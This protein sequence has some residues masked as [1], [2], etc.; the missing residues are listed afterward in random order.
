MGIVAEVGRLAACRWSPSGAYLAAGTYA[1]AVDTSFEASSSLELFALDV[2]NGR[3][4]PT[5]QPVPVSEK[6]SSIAWGPSAR[7]KPSG[8]IGGGLDDGTVAVWDPAALFRPA[9]DA[10]ARDPKRGLLFPPIAPPKHKGSVNSLEFNA[11]VGTLLA[12]GGADGQVLVWDL[13]SGTPSVHAPGALEKNSGRDEIVAIAWNKKVQHILGTGSSSGVLSVWD[14]RSRKQVISIRNPRGRLRASS[15]AWHPS[16]PTQI[17]VG[18]DEDDGSGAQLW[19]LRNATAPLVSLNHHAPRG[20]LGMS[21]CPH[22]T[23]LVLTSSRDCRTMV[24]SVSS[25]NL[26]ME[27]PKSHS[28]NFGVQWSPRSPGVYLASTFDGRVSVH[29]MLTAN[30][31][32]SVSEE[33]AKTLARLFESDEDQ[34]KSGMSAQSPRSTGAQ[35]QSVT[36]SQPPAWLRRPA[37]VSFSFGNIATV[38]Q[39]K[40]GGSVSLVSAAEP[41]SVLEESNTAVDEVLRNSSP[42]DPSSAADYCAKAASEAETQQDRMAWDVLSMQFKTDS[43][44]ELLKYF[45]YKV[46]P[47]QPGDMTDQVLGMECS[48]VLANPVRP[49]SGADASPDAQNTNTLPVSSDA[50]GT[51]LPGGANGATHGLK[52]LTL[53]GP[54]P[55]DAPV[56]DSHPGGDSILDDEQHND[57]SVVEQTSAAPAP[58]AQDSGYAKGTDLS[59][60]SGEALDQVISQALIACNFDLAVEACFHGDRMAD[61]LV[62]AQAAGPAVWKRTQAEYLAR[63]GTTGSC[64]VISAVAGPKNKMDDFIQTAASGGKDSWKDALAVIVSYLPGQEFSEACSALGQR[65]LESQNRAGAL[66]CF[67]CALN[68]RMV[69]A[70]WTTAPVCGGSVSAALAARTDCLVALIEKVRLTTAAAAL[71]YREPDIAAIRAYDEISGAALL[72]YGA[73]LAAHGDVAAAIGYVAPLDPSVAGVRGSAGDIHA[74]A[75]EALSRHG[76]GQSEMAMAPNA[77]TNAAGYATNGYS[78]FGQPNTGY[79]DYNT[80]VYGD[81]YGTN[82]PAGTVPSP[83]PAT[84]NSAWSS[85]PGMPPAPA[86]APVTPAMVQ[87]PVPVRPSGMFPEQAQQNGGYTKTFYPGETNDVVQSPSPADVPVP[88]TYSVMTPATPPV[89]EFQQPLVSSPPPPPPPAPLGGYDPSGVPGN[90]AI[91]GPPAP[92]MAGA[93]SPPPLASPVPPPSMMLGRPV[94]P[95]A[96]LAM[97]GI[98]PA[99]GMPQQ[100]MQSDMMPTP[101]PPPPTDGEPTGP[102]TMH[103]RATPG[104]GASLPPSSE[105]AVAERKKPQ[106]R[107]KAV[108]GV[109]ARNMSTSSS[110][111]SM[112]NEPAV[113]LE[114]VVVNNVPADQQVIVQSLRGAYQYALGRNSSMMYKKKMMDVSRKLGRLLFRLNAREVEEPTVRKL[115]TMAEGIGKGDYDTA[116]VLTNELSKEVDWEANR[117]WIQAMHRLIDAVLTGR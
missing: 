72:E 73:M 46:A 89:P 22:D 55:W 93:A 108:G 69:A 67:I 4:V 16:T 33:T 61:A 94:G 1:G 103:A 83:A 97:P 59:G 66:V 54:A 75:S 114:D 82:L 116:R 36:M 92:Q 29:S 26:V 58:S 31:A 8:L 63:R 76:G 23:D 65:L 96:P 39:S 117:H 84:L 115:V 68:T 12:S 79:A 86:P 56:P 42:D 77:A 104:S 13:A 21:W 110:L 95:G 102:M 32:A 30:A 17:L 41:N 2:G 109:P 106:G 88:S 105:I 62:I 9:T 5:S 20:V 10:A 51:G 91:P 70:T 14:L 38:I 74:L 50:N 35:R 48:P 80:P 112:G 107:P 100:P 101:P 111:S 27:L 90:Q 57:A 99:M 85:A 98:S 6:F 7:D 28:W 87:P 37:A 47:A 34:F 18:C 19:D 52:D 25:G 3:L 45:G 71:V 11:F 113:S 43:R 40:A 53:D 15:L 49:D 78:Q 81:G 64:G 60:L 24:T 44:R